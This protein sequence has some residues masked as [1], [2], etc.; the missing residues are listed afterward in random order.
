MAVAKSGFRPVDAEAANSIEVDLHE[1][2][3]SKAVERTRGRVAPSADEHEDRTATT[4]D[5]AERSRSVQK[6]IGRLT[7]S[8]RQEIA[9]K[10]AEFQRQLGERDA[11]IQRLELDRQ[12]PAQAADGEAQHEAAMKVLEGQHEAALEKGNSAEATRL[13]RLM[14]KSEADWATKKTVALLGK[15]AERQERKEEPAATQRA[16][17]RTVPKTADKFINA[18]I[19][20]WEDP[21][22][23]VERQGANVLFEQLV[24][25]EGFD[26]NDPKTYVELNRRLKKKFPALAVE[27]P[28]KA[29]DDRDDE[30]EDDEPVE[31]P[32]RNLRTRRAPTIDAARGGEQPVVRNGNKRRLTAEDVANMREFHL[33]PNN[34]KH[35][36]R[37]AREIEAAAALEK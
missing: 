19:G 7:R 37:Y 10:D 31:P 2:D 34:D 25:E 26:A 20:W 18:N 12:N 1:S 24:D 14:A 3:A 15:T 33:D 21:D 4:D 35:V 36:M 5:W 22:F 17:P 30:D 23:R 32:S 8:F 28:G 27:T 29:D 13:A 11:R 16:A 9:D 6:R